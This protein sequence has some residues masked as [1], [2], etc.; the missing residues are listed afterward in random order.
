[1]SAADAALDTLSAMHPA[2]S[3]ALIL[4][5]AAVLSTCCALLGALINDGLGHLAGVGG[6]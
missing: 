3:G 4:T 5:S 1:M 2:F 6:R